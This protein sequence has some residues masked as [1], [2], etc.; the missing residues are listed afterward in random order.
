MIFKRIGDLWRKRKKN[1][2]KHDDNPG[3]AGSNTNKSERRIF[4]LSRLLEKTKLVMAKAMKYKWI[5][6]IIG[7][8]IV[9]YCIIVY[10]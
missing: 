8:L 2:D 1:D 10:L 3:D 4:R 7:L 9:A 6:I 5:A